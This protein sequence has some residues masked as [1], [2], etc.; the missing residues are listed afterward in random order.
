MRKINKKTVVTVMGSACLGAALWL[1]G[2]VMA[3]DDRYERWGNGSSS[4]AAVGFDPF[5]AKE[6]GACHVAYPPGALPGRS[7]AKM[8][9]DLEN[10]FGDDASL[11]ADEVRVLT[12]YLLANAA[13]HARGDVREL[14][15]RVGRNE[16]PLKITELGYFK[17]EHREVPKRV[18]ANNPDLK[19]SNCEACHTKADQGSYRE[20]D[21]NIPGVGRWDD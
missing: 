13:E 8:M 14:T 15:K 18:Y 16:T 12:D 17:K 19:L 2:P 9:G 11:E 3:D 1:A 5:Y 21:I 7:W 20:R 6:C 10:H 4:G